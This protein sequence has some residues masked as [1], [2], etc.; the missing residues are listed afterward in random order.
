M[1]RNPD[2]CTE[3]LCKTSSFLILLWGTVCDCC[4]LCWLSS[5][6]WIHFFFLF[7]FP[8]LFSSAL[9]IVLCG[10]MSWRKKITRVCGVAGVKME[11]SSFDLQSLFSLTELPVHILENI[12]CWSHT[13]VK[14]GKRKGERTD[15][16]NSEIKN[17]DS[18][19]R[20]YLLT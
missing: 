8:H 7:C 13:I 6:L 19:D 10:K 20:S 5:I 14:F 17:K 9:L 2:L 18:L 15:N 16:K 3:S 12:R 4:W 1:A 11:F